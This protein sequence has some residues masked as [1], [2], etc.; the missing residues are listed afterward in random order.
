MGTKSHALYPNPWTPPL[1]ATAD[2]P[3]EETPAGS[4]VDGI[5]FWTTLVLAIFGLIF[6]PV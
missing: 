3:P 1:P 5:V 4:E 6:V 2:C